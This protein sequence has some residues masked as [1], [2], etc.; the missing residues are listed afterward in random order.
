M[1]RVLF[2]VVAGV[3][4]LF[5]RAATAQDSLAQRL[6]SDRPGQINCGAWL[7]GDKVGFALEPA[8]AN[9]LLRFDGSPEVFVLHPDKAALGGKVLRYD[10]GDTA[11]Q[12]SG[13]GGLTLY[14]DADPAGIPAARSGDAAIEEPASV[15]LAELATAA[16]DESENLDRAGRFDL[17]FSTDWN[18]LSDSASARALAM[19]AMGNVARGIERFGRTAQGREKLSRR[20][21]SVT[22]AVAGRPTVTLNGRTLIVTFDPEHGYDGRAS[23]RVIARALATLLAA[24]QKPG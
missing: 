19:D 20:L 3:A 11:L 9:F 1:P 17:A 23:S 24:P 8:G 15:S 21:S 13:W 12:V 7:A 4:L 18:E 2:G 10:S 16:R 5:V 14:T 22:L 6:S